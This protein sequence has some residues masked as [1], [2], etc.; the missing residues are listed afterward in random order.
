MSRGRAVVNYHDGMMPI[1]Y[2]VHCELARSGIRLPRGVSVVSEGFIQRLAG[3]NLFVEKRRKQPCLPG[4]GQPD[5]AH[6]FARLREKLAQPLNANLDRQLSFA[7]RACVPN[8]TVLVRDVAEVFACFGRHAP[9]AIR[10]P[11]IKRLTN[12]LPDPCNEARIVANQ[13]AMRV[14][15]KKSRARFLYPFTPAT[16]SRIAALRSRSGLSVTLPC[17]ET[18]T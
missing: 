12:C 1:R 10:Q 5:Q 2:E 3:L 16:A 11:A 14:L 17:D 18:M 7:T 9:S 4:T 13:L 15:S 8:P 6:D